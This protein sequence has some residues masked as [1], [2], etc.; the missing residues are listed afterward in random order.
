MPI[1]TVLEMAIADIALSLDDDF[2][3]DSG[4]ESYLLRLRPEEQLP[5]ALSCSTHARADMRLLASR[6]LSQASYNWP[7]LREPACKRLREILATE[8]DPA[9]LGEAAGAAG[10]WGDEASL[11]LLVS[12]KAHTEFVV[13]WG[14]VHGFSGIETKEAKLHLIELAQDDDDD[15]RDWAVF[16][17]GS[18]T[19]LDFPELREA[20]VAALD[21]GFHMVRFEATAGLIERKDPRAVPALKALLESMEDDDEWSAAWAL[22]ETLRAP[23]LV[24]VLQKQFERY[25]ESDQ[26]PPMLAA[27]NACKGFT[28]E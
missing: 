2:G 13:K 5:L 11:Q 10:K 23:E 15:I 7:E 12:L 4:A 24:P 17:L 14:L 25:S 28:S 8:T 22:A 21:D 16:G 3:L 19:Q 26:E 20:L 6:L 1:E 9:V 18:L 27:L